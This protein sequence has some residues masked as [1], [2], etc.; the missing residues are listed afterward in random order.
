M[1]AARLRG[2]SIAMALAL[3]LAGCG[4]A[5]STTSPN[6][7]ATGDVG[8]SGQ[9]IFNVQVAF[10][11]DDNI[12]GSFVDNDTGTGYA[13][14]AEYAT[15]N[16]TG[17]GVWLSP[18]P[19]A[20]ADTQIGGKSLTFAFMVSIDTFHGP[21]TYA[22]SLG[23]LV[24]GADTFMRGTTGTSTVTLNGDGSGDGSFSDF[25]DIGAASGTESG[26]VSWTCSG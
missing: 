15:F 8:G 18:G 26:T 13:S 3:V 19:P 2:S 9:I 21:A 25:S 12:Q 4:S 10:T 6:D 1:I 11:G 17:V 16:P 24:I 14:C 20:G 5:A 7:Q 22:D 23:S